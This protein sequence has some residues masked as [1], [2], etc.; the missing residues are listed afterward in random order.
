MYVPNCSGVIGMGSSASLDSRSRSAGSLSASL[1]ALLSVATIARGEVGRADDAIP[2]HAVEA[3]V[4]EF[5]ERRH[6]G[7]Q[8]V[9]L[10]TRHR[11]RPHLAR[12]DV[13]QRGG[14]TG[15]QRLRLAAEDVGD[16]RA[17]AAIRDVLEV[18]A[19]LY[20]EL[21][22]RQMRERP[23]TRRTVGELAF[24]RLR[25]VDELWQRLHRQRR[26]NDEDVGR[27]TDHRDGREILDRIV[28]QLAHRRI[29]AVCAHV[30]DHQRVAVGRGARGCLRADDAAAAAL[31]LDDDGLAKRLLQAFANRPGDEIDAPARL[32]RRDDLDRLRRVGPLCHRNA[33]HPRDYERCEPPQRCRFT[34]G[35]HQSSS[36]DDQGHRRQMPVDSRLPHGSPRVFLPVTRDVS[37][38]RTPGASA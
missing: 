20:L 1:I 5:F 30:A 35:C 22:H 12:L 31:V 6:V 4:A 18:D 7:Q 8:R 36:L 15:K 16:C 38:G 33:G 14:E 27:A 23:R 11:E 37:I 34:P 10:G 13:R 19:G 2:L 9:S 25:V 21:L 24:V 26:G 29:R 17:D 28:G 3:L 32:H